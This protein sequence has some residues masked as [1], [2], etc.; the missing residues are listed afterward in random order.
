MQ[1]S[2]PYEA[3]QTQARD[4]R[5]EYRAADWRAQTGLTPEAAARATRDFFLAEGYRL[6]AGDLHNAVYGIGT[7]MTRILF[8]GFAKRYK[9]KVQI[10]PS[11]AGCSVQVDKGM[12]GIMG[13]A[14]GYS[15]MKTELVRVRE[16]LHSSLRRRQS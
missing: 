1:M 12:S 3:P 9:F 6:E 4:V 5:A 10:I 15:K 7:T 13:G 16:A 2:N 14:I 8:G 11:E